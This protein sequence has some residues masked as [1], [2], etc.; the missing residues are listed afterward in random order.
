MDYGKGIIFEGDTLCYEKIY[1]SSKRKTNSYWTW[2][3]LMICEI[4]DLNGNKNELKN[5]IMLIKR[6]S[7]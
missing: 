3:V 2:N 1:V 5:Y 7:F 4:E 6:P